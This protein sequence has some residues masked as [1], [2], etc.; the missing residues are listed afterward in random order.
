M[1]QSGMPAP[2]NVPCGKEVNGRRYP[3]KPASW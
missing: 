2:A 3:A 1:P